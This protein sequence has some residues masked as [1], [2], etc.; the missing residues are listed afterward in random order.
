M[1]HNPRPEPTPNQLLAYQ[2]AMADP[3]YWEEAQAM[4]DAASFGPDEW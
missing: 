4:E 1:A 2:E 3:R